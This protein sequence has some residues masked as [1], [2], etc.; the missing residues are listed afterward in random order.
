MS[1]VKL[2]PFS[3]MTYHPLTEEIVEMLSITTQ[4][5]NKHMFRT[6]LTYYWGMIGTH[7]RANIIGWYSSRLPMNIYSI[8]L[9]ES[10]TG[11]GYT[12]STMEDH[13][14]SKFRNTFMEETFPVA[15]EDGME[16][17]ALY[18]ASK[19]NTNVDAER[20]KLQKEFD[21]AGNMLFSFSEGTPAALKQLRHKLVI[22][23]AGS[24]NFQVDEI[25]NNLI[26]SKEMMNLYLE[27]YDRGDIKEKL[28]KNT[29][30]NK[31]VEALDGFTPTNMLLFGTS[32]S[33]LDG[34]ETENNFMSLLESGYARRSFFSFSQE[35]NKDTELTAE[36]IVE[37]MFNQHHEDSYQEISDHIEETA[38]VSNLDRELTID[39]ESCLYLVMYKMSCEERARKLKTHQKIL[40]AELQ[41][42]YF[43]VLKAAAGYVFV[44]HGSEITIEY[45]EYA[46]KLAE[47]SGKELERLL[48]PDKDFMR[49]ARFLAEQDEEV[50]LPDIELG[51]PC[52]SGSQSKKMEMI[53]NATAWGYKNNCLITKRYVDQILFL[54][55][56]PLEPTNL[57]ELFI[58]VSDHEAY[59]YDN[60]I[61]SFEALGELGEVRYMHWINHHVEDGHRLK[62]NVIPGFNCIVLDVDDGTPIEA[63]MRMF[64]GYYAVFYDT[65][66]STAKH[67]RYRI[68]LPTNYILELENEDYADFM[69]NLISVLPFE[70]DSCVCEREHKWQTWDAGADVVGTHFVN[71]VEQ[72]C[73]LFNVLDYI[74]RTT[75]NEERI[76]KAK[77]Y[78]NLDGLQY[79]VMTTTAEGNRNKQLYRYAMILVDN[80]YDYDTISTMVKAMNDGLKDGIS[81][82]ELSNTIMS[83]VARKI[84]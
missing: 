35:A 55:G 18:R 52:F 20:G 38:D 49:L 78:E 22:A 50:T 70:V 61:T 37:L 58:S 80:G 82:K 15:A 46:M 16:D 68:I 62:E 26:G 3:E 72:P 74:P 10:G 9:A 57:D 14:I 77:D 6:M 25:G 79:W 45:L 39:R 7:M 30:E 59:R 19:R 69:N 67:N 48:N 2:K 42:R 75:K 11:K 47:E 43:K 17:I 5:S 4:S 36:D 34:G 60:Q 54:D 23:N 84:K 29:A 65:K 27:L 66:S 64:E 83:T 53:A 13:I 56:K 76:K 71:G 32:S 73:S 40:K 24:L 81:D 44:D 21:D 1:K 31:R 51:L 12:M 8:V 63:A 41:H 28:I 33:L